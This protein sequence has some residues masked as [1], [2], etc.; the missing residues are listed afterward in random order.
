M[1][2]DFAG[3]SRTSLIM[4]TDACISMDANCASPV[5]AEW[6]PSESYELNNGSQKQ[7]APF[8]PGD[9]DAR[10]TS[11]LG[12]E[13]TAFYTPDRMALYNNGNSDSPAYLDC[14]VV[15]GSMDLRV[16]YPGDAAYTPNVGS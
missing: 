5:Q 10:L 15:L 8:Q 13:R 16:K 4:L 3:L 14:H 1:P 7:S 11:V 6:T 12:L 2:A 9:W